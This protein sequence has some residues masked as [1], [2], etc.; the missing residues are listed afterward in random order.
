MSFNKSLVVKWWIWKLSLVHF[1][2]I[3]LIYLCKKKIKLLL[4]ENKNMDVFLKYSV[5]N[6][7]NAAKL[8]I[9]RSLH[10]LKEENYLIN[11]LPNIV[12]IC[13]WYDIL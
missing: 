3:F 7:L 12:K 10:Q 11:S 9:T 13:R 1:C 6:V 8:M 2:L 5:L 4:R